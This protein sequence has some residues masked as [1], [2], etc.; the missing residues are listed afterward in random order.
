MSYTITE[1]KKDELNGSDPLIAITLV[2][3]NDCS[4]SY[5]LE[6]M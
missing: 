6:C 3:L 2:L 4:M 5:L 1:Y